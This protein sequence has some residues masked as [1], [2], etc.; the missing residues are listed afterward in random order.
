MPPFCSSAKSFGSA[1]FL[2]ITAMEETA[3]ANVG[4]FRRDGTGPRPKGRD[5]LRD[6]AAK[7]SMAVLSTVFMS[8]RIVDGFGSRPGRGSR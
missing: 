1:A 2:S 6:Y 8:R 3:K 4:L 5:L 7:H